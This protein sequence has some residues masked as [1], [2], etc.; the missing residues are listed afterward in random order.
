MYNPQTKRY[1]REFGPFLGYGIVGKTIHSYVSQREINTSKKEVYYI[2]YFT[3]SSYSIPKQNI[4]LKQKTLS[5]MYHS[6]SPRTAYAMTHFTA[7]I[8]VLGHHSLFQ[9]SFTPE[10]FERYQRIDYYEYKKRFKG[11][12]CVIHA[13]FSLGL[14]NV[15]EAKK[16]VQVMDYRSRNKKNEGVA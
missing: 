9:V 3:F 15:T 16:D 6:T 13:L 7:P 10:Q 8:K 5:F 1:V 14:R 12:S 2:T 11:G 4:K